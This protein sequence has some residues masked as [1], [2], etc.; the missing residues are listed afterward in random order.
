[1]KASTPGRL[2]NFDAAQRKTF[3]SALCHLL[4]TEFT[5]H[6]GPAVTDLFARKI[7]QLFD[8]FHPDHDRLKL[9]QVLWSGVAIDDPPARNKRIEN[10]RLVPIV[11]DLV[12]LRDIEEAALPAQRLATRSAKIVRLFKQAHQQGALLGNADLALLLHVS[13]GVVSQTVV[14]EERRTGQLVPRRGTIHDLGP[15]VSH[16]GVICYQR[17]IEH[18]TTSQIAQETSH[19]PEEVEYYIS[20]FQRVKLCQEA[21]MTTTDEIAQV[22]GQSKA[23]VQQYLDL[24]ARLHPTPPEAPPQTRPQR[25]LNKR[26]VN[27]K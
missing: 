21:G 26:T 4:Q 16:K 6:F 8:R 10:T 24:I 3:H 23:L 22:T 17:F 18:K 14:T 13:L 19:S 7:E 11:L 5:G 2:V 12:T 9:G 20:C 1:M 15:S 25:H 27:A